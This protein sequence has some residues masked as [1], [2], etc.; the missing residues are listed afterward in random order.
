MA[1]KAGVH[2][3]GKATWGGRE[4]NLGE[5]LRRESGER[6]GRE[7]EAGE[8]LRREFDERLLKEKESFVD[9]SGESSVN[10]WEERGSW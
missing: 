2:V 4:R 8:R 7:R 10:V 3:R 1:R 6:L 9:V 5:R